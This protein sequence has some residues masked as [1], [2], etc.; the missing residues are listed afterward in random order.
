VLSIE[1]SRELPGARP[2]R[3]P[4]IRLG[5]KACL[6]DPNATALL[7]EAAKRA[8]KAQRIRLTGGTCEATA[9]QTYGYEAGGVAIPLVNYHNGWGAKM[10]GPEKVR[11][12]DVAGIQ[13]LL[14]QPRASS[15]STSCAGPCARGWTG[16][17]RASKN[18]S[19]RADDEDLHAHRR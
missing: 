14:V 10:I 2:G 3:G 7:D 12:E 16:A 5:D 8:G 19:A 17:T 9:Y 18:S 6:F 11:L 15:P 13:E 4:V 1:T